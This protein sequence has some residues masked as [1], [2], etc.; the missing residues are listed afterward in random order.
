MFFENSIFL[1]FLISYSFS[2]VS[3]IQVLIGKWGIWQHE[4]VK[5][6]LMFKLLQ[7]VSMYVLKQF[8]IDTRYTGN[9]HI[10]QIWWLLAAKIYYEKW[11]YAFKVFLSMIYTFAHA[12]KPLVEALFLLQLRHLQS[13]VF[14][15]FN[16]IFR[17]RKSLTR[18]K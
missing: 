5:S 12:L 14:E 10:N 16:I 18:R 8:H 2:Q 3:S 1:I 17:R 13:M 4:N 6:N 15:R 11:F 9:S 7:Q